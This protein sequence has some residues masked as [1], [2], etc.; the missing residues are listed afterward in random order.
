MMTIIN[1]VVVLFGFLN[2]ALDVMLILTVQTASIHAYVRIDA[3]QRRRR[4][5]RRPHCALQLR[6]TTPRF[7]HSRYSA[8][9]GPFTGAFKGTFKRHS[10]GQAS[11]RTLASDVRN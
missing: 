1:E 8:F 7:H 11:T 9:K 6:I 3:W 10:A 5:R 2:Q 4:R